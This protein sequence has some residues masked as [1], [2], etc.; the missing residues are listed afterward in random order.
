[1]KKEIWLVAAKRTPIGAFQ[2]VLASTDAG[3]LGAKAI[4]A[5]MKQSRLENEKIDEVLMGCV[6]TAGVGQAPARQAALGAG[7]PESIGATTLNKVCGSG[8]KTVMLACDLINAGSAK[9]VVAGGM[10]NM[11]ASPYLMKKAREGFRLGH[12]QV[13]DHMFYDGLQDAYQGNLMGVYAEQTAQEFNFSRESMDSW[14]QQSLSRAKQSINDGLFRDEIVPVEVKSRRSTLLVEGDEQPAKLDIDKIPTLKPAFA[15]DGS[16]TAANSSS[17]SDGASAVVLV[18]AEFGRQQNLQPLAK[19]VAH[20]THAR[21][22]Q[23]F[24]IAPVNAIEALLD[25]TGWQKSD[26]DLWEINEAFAVVTQHAV[27]A[28]ELD[29]EKV[30]PRGGACALGHPIGASGNRILVTLVHALKQSGGKRGIASL[31][32][33]GG[34]ATAVAVEII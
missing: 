26:V 15:K 27:K 13:L 9:A 18:D 3:T 19:I 16:V 31:C 22:P 28:L 25:K 6:L 33:G 21:K 5:A 7:L 11:S 12:E 32:I 23:Q 2:G 4:E 1:M 17:I 34:E 14:A 20:A 24:T 8:M 29:A 30:N 10:E